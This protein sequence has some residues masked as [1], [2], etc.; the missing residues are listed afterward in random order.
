VNPIS[1]I[2]GLVYP[3]SFVD[4]SATATGAAVV[5]ELGQ[6]LNKTNELVE[7]ITDLDSETTATI[8]ALDVR[9]D[10]LEDNAA[11]YGVTGST[12]VN[13]T[14]SVADIRAWRTL[15]CSKTGANTQVEVTLPCVGAAASLV[16]VGPLKVVN[17]GLTVS[18]VW[19]A[20]GGHW[21]DGSDADVLLKLADGE[22]C[23]VLP[24]ASRTTPADVIW[25]IVG[26][27]EYADL[28][29]E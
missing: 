6:L 23:E 25:F 12:L 1:T 9:V 24:F 22:W 18:N 2:S 21:G 4:G 5:A 13:R 10:V 14:L 28:E 27:K 11:T 29:I 17:D 20:S 8:S 16:G 19:V 15:V 7:G 3:A 26:G